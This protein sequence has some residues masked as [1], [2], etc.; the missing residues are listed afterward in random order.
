MPYWSQHCH[1]CAY[2]ASGYSQSPS[3]Y[4]YTQLPP[5]A[6]MTN[7]YDPYQPQHEHMTLRCSIPDLE[8]RATQ[9]AKDFVKRW[10]RGGD[11]RSK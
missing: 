5:V 8:A 2:A 10:G 3:S 11:S 9:A 7:G 1:Q 4:G 6:M